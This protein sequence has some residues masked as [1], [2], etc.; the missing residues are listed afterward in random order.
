MPVCVTD[1]A[2]PGRWERIKDLYAD[3]LELPPAD[4]PGFLESTGSEDTRQW[5]GRLHAVSDT[6]VRFFDTLCREIGSLGSAEHVLLPGDLLCGRFRI[7]RFLAQGG[8]GQVYE[9]SDLE[10]KVSVA[11]KVLQPDLAYRPDMLDRFLAEIRL[12]RT[13]NSPYVCRVYDVARHSRSGMTD[14]VFFTMEL[15]EGETLADYLRRTGPLP[16]SEAKELIAGMTEGLAAAH[17]L[18]VLHRDFKPGNVW[19]R[20]NESGQRRVVITD[21]GLARALRDDAW[22]P[23]SEGVTP[24]FVAP[25]QVRHA[26]ESPATDIYS[27]GLVIYQMM[28]GRLPFEGETATE[29]LR[30]RLT[31]LPAHPRQFRPDL[32][33]WWESAILRCL[34]RDP[35]RR[36]QHVTQ[37]ASALGCGTSDRAFSRR[38]WLAAAGVAVVSAVAWREWSSASIPPPVSIAVLPFE[39][40]DESA[41]YLAEGIAD[42]LTDL[43]TAAPGL[44]V[45]ARSASYRAR[46]GDA[47]DAS[48]GKRLGVRYLFGG[49]LSSGNG[50]LRLTSQIVEAS[51]GYQV[52][53]G[54]DDFD[55]LSAEAESTRLTQAA[56][57]ALH[58]DTM[59]AQSAAMQ[60][61]STKPEAYQKYLLGRFYASRRDRSSANESIRLLREAVDLDPK[62]ASAFAALGYS[63]YDLSVH[64]PEHW[65]Q[66]IA[67]SLRAADAALRL[68]PKLPEAYF[69]V[70]CTQSMWQRDWGGAERNFRRAIELNPSLAEAHHYYGNML[71]AMAR[72]AEALREIEISL[73]L[74]PL[75]SSLMVAKGSALHY[76]GRDQEALEQYAAVLRSDPGYVNVYIPRSDVLESLGRLKEAVEDC[77]RAVSLTQRASYALADLGRLYGRSGDTVRARS[78]LAELQDR[79]RSGNATATDVAYL[80]LGLGD[81]D[82]T[83]EWLERGYQNHDINVRLLKVGQEFEVLRTDRR[84][85]ELVARLGI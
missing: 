39:V 73:S 32:S 38:W 81:W 24:A 85:R 36:F 64:E 25:E 67:D 8:M 13:V 23:G 9:A 16:V 76:A 31:D 20:L 61:A 15:L 48:I 51:T 35:A 53:A 68:D 33:R 59:P 19:L 2:E 6:A 28:T 60:G 80:W 17:D 78:I 37:V 45:I 84:Y 41:R 26:A 5:V 69:V 4:R 57:R 40:S 72:H 56:I 83:F 1:G 75:S 66:H 47:N 7:E 3:A 22:S 12:A 49:R 79:Y 71:S 29:V 27:F 58:I 34:E 63:Y 55:D 74:D 65:Q 62:F 77:E 18:S 43:L 44:R 46:Q 11:L 10:L 52:W 30:R 50:K 82:R 21:F 14:L 54:T 42:R 70:A